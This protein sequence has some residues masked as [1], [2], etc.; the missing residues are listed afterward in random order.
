MTCRVKYRRAIDSL[1]RKPGGFH[2]YPHR[3]DV[4]PTLVF[5]REWERLKGW[6][7]PWRADI[8]YVRVLNLARKTMESEAASALELQLESAHPQDNNAVAV[9]YGSR[10][11][12][13]KIV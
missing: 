4:F 5:S 13:K 1:L 11:T 2:D 12:G 9:V 10:T 3:V 7:S 6:L 8:V